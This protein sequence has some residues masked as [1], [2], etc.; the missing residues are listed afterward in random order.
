MRYERKD[1][2]ELYIVPYRIAY[3]YSIKENKIL[4]L[5]IYHK[6]KQ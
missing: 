5:D 2:R 3:F 6:D 1:T 4:F